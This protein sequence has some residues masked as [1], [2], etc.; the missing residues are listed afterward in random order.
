MRQTLHKERGARKSGGDAGDQRRN[1]QEEF[2]WDGQREG[3][4]KGV[5]EELKG[6]K[7]NSRVKFCLYLGGCS[8]ISRCPKHLEIWQG[9]LRV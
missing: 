9:S 4:G 3:V 8:R 1:E 6:Q 2:F 5:K 7:G